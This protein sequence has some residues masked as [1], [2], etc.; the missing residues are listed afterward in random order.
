MLDALDLQRR[1]TYYSCCAGEGTAPET[2]SVAGTRL[3]AS[4]PPEAAV[5]VAGWR[6][7][8][9]AIRSQRRSGNRS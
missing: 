2:T 9:A 3:D 1:K 8:R 5:R 4:A 6:R 7:F